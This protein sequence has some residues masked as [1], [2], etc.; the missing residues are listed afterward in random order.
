MNKT[1]GSFP[2]KQLVNLSNNSNR[3]STQNKKTVK[4]LHNQPI[5]RAKTYDLN[6]TRNTQRYQQ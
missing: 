1:Y 6:V 3:K 4:I 5:G 2:S